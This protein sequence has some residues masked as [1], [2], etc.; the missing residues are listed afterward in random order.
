MSQYNTKFITVYSPQGGN[1]KSVLAATIAEIYALK[2]Y[3]TILVDAAEYGS[4]SAILNI[5]FAQAHGFDM[6]L[7]RIQSELEEEKKAEYLRSG[8]VQHE[9]IKKLKMLLSG[10]PISISLIKEQRAEEICS[11]LKS[12]N[13]DIV[14]FDTSSELSLFKLTLFEMS[15][16]VIVPIKGD[17]TSVLRT[18]LLQDI[19][20]QSGFASSKLNLILNMKDKKTSLSEDEIEKNCGS[21]VI[22]SIPDFGA[23]FRKKCNE[24]ILPV[25]MRGKIKKIFLEAAE[26]ILN[27]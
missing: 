6:M 8:L 7:D 18:G 21:K 17:L 20:R 24:G 25:K 5:P 15:E 11:I 1:G 9:T 13:A 4:L 27:Y 26:K 22:C 19:W 14:I 16:K 10:D 2:G 12:Q 3:E 23:E